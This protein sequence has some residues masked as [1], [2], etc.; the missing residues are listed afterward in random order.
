MITKQVYFIGTFLLKFLF[1]F[2]RIFNQ[3]TW[4]LK[5]VQ[6]P[7]GI[8]SSNLGIK[9]PQLF[10]LKEFLKEFLNAFFLMYV[11][12]KATPIYVNILDNIVPL[13]Y[14]IAV[15]NFSNEEEDSYR[16]FIPTVEY[17]SFILEA[18]IYE[19]WS[20]ISPYFW[21]I[22]YYF[23]QYI[24]WF[25]NVPESLYF[26]IFGIIILLTSVYI[27]ETNYRLKYTLVVLCL[28]PL[29]ISVL[30]DAFSF[31]NTRSLESFTNFNHF[32]YL[33][34]YVFL[35]TFFL[36]LSESYYL[37]QQKDIRPAE[38]FWFYI[39]LIFFGY[40]LFQFN[41]NVNTYFIIFEAISFTTIIVL[42]FTT[43]NYRFS[44]LSSARYLLIG[45]LPTL[46]I[47]LMVVFFFANN[48][49]W[50]ITPFPVVQETNL[51]EL[52][53]YLNSNEE[54]KPEAE[55][56]QLKQSKL[57]SQVES[58]A[59]KNY[60]NGEFLS[61]WVNNSELNKFEQCTGSR[62]EQQKFF[63]KWYEAFMSA[64]VDENIIKVTKEVRDN[65][66]SFLEQTKNDIKLLD[67][68]NNKLASSEMK[69]FEIEERMAK[70]RT[71]PY[72]TND[73]RNHTGELKYFLETW[74]KLNSLRNIEQD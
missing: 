17:I 53:E 40:C 22:F 70:Q 25:E 35:L 69:V 16:T 59:K 33:I 74:Q 18:C 72:V 11:I 65:Y 44:I 31:S 5:V 13:E 36:A 61:Y 50:D 20:I 14:Y 4:T 67:T 56:L 73:I 64:N 60:I 54:F 43:V 57:L 39:V 1:F 2:Y 24:I 21:L 26:L 12:V 3:K 42:Q 27:F 52:L 9:T 66:K 34:I 49:F 63:N 37:T 23:N 8:S 38:T 47:L 45:F 7:N 58:M 46:F 15:S 29:F 71:M 68:T 30:M 48:S 28:L 51:Y 62:L 41:V 32:L 6:N 55:I 10:I 19:Y